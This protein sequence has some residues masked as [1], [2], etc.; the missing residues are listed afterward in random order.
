MT[1]KYS[2]AVSV[3]PDDAE[4]DDRRART[5]VGVHGQKLALSAARGRGPGGGGEEAARAFV[6]MMMPK[7]CVQ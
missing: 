5:H 3:V 1:C 7:N 4:G 2:S 6:L